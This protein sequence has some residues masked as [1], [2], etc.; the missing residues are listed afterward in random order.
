MGYGVLGCWLQACM[1]ACL[2]LQWKK[3]PLP[4]SVRYSTINLPS[5]RRC[6]SR[7]S[8]LPPWA[9]TLARSSSTPILVC[10]EAKSL[11]SSFSDARS[12]ISANSDA[13]K[14]G[15]RGAAHETRHQQPSPRASESDPSWNAM[16]AQKTHAGC[17][18]S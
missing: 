7:L 11:L 13:P 14:H 6:S 15:P 3:G 12:C 4:W 2:A 17:V 16:H 8:P 1:Q 18:L 5:G 10:Q 9:Q